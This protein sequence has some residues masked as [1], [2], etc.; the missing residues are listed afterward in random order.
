MSKKATY[1]GH[2][3]IDD[4]LSKI[5]AEEEAERE[6]FHNYSAEEQ[7][8]LI[9]LARFF[10]D[11]EKFLRTGP[12]ILN[13]DGTWPVEPMAT[14]EEFSAANSFNEIKKEYGDDV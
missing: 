11:M 9:R 7:L 14:K 6:R 4:V 13:P 1:A 2:E 5:R 12:G 10:R 3:W 8:K